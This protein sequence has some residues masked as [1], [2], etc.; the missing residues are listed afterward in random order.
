MNIIMKR[1]LLFSMLMMFAVS[2]VA[3]KRYDE[4][5]YPKLNEF[6]KANVEEF[7]LDNGIKF[8]LVEDK[9]LPLIRVSATIRTGSLQDPE[10]KEGLASM[11]GELMREGGSVNYPA[12]KLNVLLEDKAAFMSTFIGQGSG[13]ASM[14]ILKE[15]FDELL[16]V[17]VDLVQNPLFPEDKI[18]LSKTQRKSGISRRNDDQASIA[19]REYSKLIYGENSPLTRQIEYATLDAISREDIVAFHKEA[20]VGNNMTFGVIGDFDTKEMKKKLEEAF[21]SL[22]AGTENN[23][24][25]P[26]I[27]Y[28]FPS[29][30]NFINKSDVNQSYVLVGHIGGLREN[31]DYAKIQMMNQILGGGFAGRLFQTVR[32]DLG[33]AYAVGGGYGSNINYPGTFSLFVMTKSSTTAQAID[34]LIAEVEKMQ[35]NPV[36]KK[37]LEDARD[38]FLN[39]LVFR[40]DSKQKILNERISNEYNGLSKDAFDKYVEDLKKVTVSDIQQVAK[41][42][43]NPDKVQIL[44]VGNAEEVGDQLQKYGNVNEI[45][46]TIPTPKSDKAEVTGDAAKGKEWLGK[47]A[48]AVIEPRT[49]LETITTV[50][51]IDQAT[52]SGTMS[53]KN[54]ASISYTD[55]SIDATLETP[56]GSMK[57]MVENG[58]GKMIMMGQEQALPSAMTKPMVDD[59][60]NS[61]INVALNADKLNAEY[62]GMEQMNGENF[63]VLKVQSASTVTFLLDPATALPA[64]SKVSSFN[65]QMGKEVETITSYSDWKVTNGVAYAFA[66]ETK[67][68]GQVTSSSTVESVEIN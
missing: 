4:I 60:K 39:S 19:N 21:G 50:S 57:M 33:L 27:N 24:I 47:M 43:L 64:F 23:L 67:T 40:Y 42:Y 49:N 36:T 29:T 66:Q 65:P 53:I 48:D 68:D 56:Q 30:V 18:E 25:Y 28:S 15:D 51:T 11:T 52:P 54:T 46:I 41:E 7:Q 17:F 3:Q 34:A 1:T 63:I 26:E 31:P 55:Y 13:S 38:R 62:L 22:P 58:A 9:E 45:D 32:T 44:V 6:K 5:K 8:Y 12:D 20:F 61:Y 14:N 10:G 2:A 59:V 16:P 35:T 37:E